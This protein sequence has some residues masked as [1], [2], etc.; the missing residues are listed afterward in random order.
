MCWSVNKQQLQNRDQWSNK[1]HLLNPAI[2]ESVWL[3][4]EAPSDSVQGI[5]DELFGCR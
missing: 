4:L 5:K 2:K 3:V 1:T